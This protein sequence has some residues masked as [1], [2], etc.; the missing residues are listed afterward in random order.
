MAGLEAPADGVHVGRVVAEPAGERVGPAVEGDAHLV[1]LHLADAR[2]A[3]QERHLTHITTLITLVPF[4]HQLKRNLSTLTHNT[5]G[6][7]CR[8]LKILT[9]QSL[10]RG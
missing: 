9:I 5:S 10:W 1:A 6:C 4:Q 2:H 3:D 7:K 8:L